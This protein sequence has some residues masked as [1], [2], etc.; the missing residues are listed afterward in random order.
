MEDFRDRVYGWSLNLIEKGHILEGIFLLLS[1]WNFAYFRYHMIDF[2]LN[3]FEDILRKCDF[4]FFK[5][6]R[7]ET[8]NLSDAEIEKRIESMYGSLSGIEAIRYVGA[9]KIMHLLNPDLFMMWDNSVIKGYAGKMGR[10]A[11]NTSSKGYMNFMREMQRGFLNGEFP[12][13]QQGETVPRAIDI[14]NLKAFPRKS[15]KKPS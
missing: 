2:K 12:K 1:T 15:S 6:K 11:I 7:F 14:Y 13:P 5:S 10:R 9:T 3:E 8:A 4:D